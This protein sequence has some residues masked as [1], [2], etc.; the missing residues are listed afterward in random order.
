MKTAQDFHCNFGSSALISAQLYAGIARLSFGLVGQIN[1]RG[2]INALNQINARGQV[3]VFGTRPFAR[4]AVVRHDT[5]GAAWQHG[6]NETTG[7]SPSGAAG[8][9]KRGSMAAW[10]KP[11]GAMPIAPSADRPNYQYGNRMKIS[12]LRSFN[13]GRLSAHNSSNIVKTSGPSLG[14]LAVIYY[15]ILINVLK[16]PNLK[17]GRRTDHKPRFS[18]NKI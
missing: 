1:A 5:G 18:I 11:G 16:M 2:Q 7:H 13:G 17:T 3:H 6:P 10:P 4:Y 9:H 12:L 15:M 14:P 8:W